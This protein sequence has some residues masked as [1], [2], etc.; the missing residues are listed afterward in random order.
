MKNL[1]ESAESELDYI[2]SLEKL[3]GQAAPPEDLYEA[4]ET[5][6]GGSDTREDFKGTMMILRKHN[7]QDL[8]WDLMDSLENAAKEVEDVEDQALYENMIVTGLDVLDAVESVSNHKT[9][10]AKIEVRNTLRKAGD[11]FRRQV[12]SIER[13]A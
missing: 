9:L 1:P 6:F 4:L 10:D 12:H 11:D 13:A 7:E 8:V 2:A 3:L 5:I